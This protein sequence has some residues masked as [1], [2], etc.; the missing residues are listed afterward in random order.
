MNQESEHPHHGHEKSKAEHGGDHTHGHETH[1]GVKPSSIAAYYYYCPMCEGVES[2]KPGT[3][4]KCGMALEKNPTHPGAGKTI[5]TCPMHPEIE[6]DHPGNCPICGM[7]LE[8][9]TISAVPEENHEL[10]DMTWRLWIGTALALPVLI[11]SMGEMLFAHLGLSARLSQWIQF[12]LSTPVVWWIGWPFLERGFRSV[13]TWNLN[14]FTLIALG[15]ETAYL[16]S[17]VA[18]LA[19]DWF[20]PEMRTHGGVVGV[21]FE[22][23][24]VI[25]VLVA[26]GQVLE[27]RARSR[28]H[29]AIRGLLDLTPKMAHVVR[30]GHENDIP[31]DE[32]KVGDVLRVR[33][34]ER[35][36]VDG[37]I[38]DGVSAVDESTLTGESIPA[39]KTKGS[40]VSGGTLNGTGSF[41]IRAER[42]GAETLLAQIVQLVAQAQRSRAPIQ[43]IADKVSGIFVPAVVAIAA[44]TFIAWMIWGPEPTLAYA[45]TNAV[46]VL[47]IAC[48]CALGL[49]TPMSIMVG[50]GRGAHEGVLIKNAEALGKMEKVNTLV[51]DKTGTLSEGKPRVV[52]VRVESGVSETELISW[53]AAVE[54]LSEHPL[55]A[56][57]VQLAKARNLAVPP[58]ENFESFTGG[59]VSGTVNGRQVVIGQMELL[60]SN[61]IHAT[62]TEAEKMRGDG[63][64]VV[65]VGID[66]HLAGLLGIADPIKNGTPDALRELKQLGLRLI[67]LT[68]DHERTANAIASK[69]GINEVHAGVKPAEKHALIER[70]RAERNIVAMAGDG[71]NDAPALAAADVGIAMGTGTDV[72]MQSASVTLVKGDLTGIVRAVHLSRSVMRNIRQNLFLSFVY[73]ALGVPIAAGVL[74]PFTGWLLNPMIASVAMS[75]SSVSV[76]V[77]ALRLRHRSL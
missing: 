55:A 70:L 76:I 28:T 30:D 39:E 65:F 27:L 35:V 23:A 5:Y 75:L 56:A 44:L 67:M 40:K 68:G 32:V 61:H 48:P 66:G 59:G 17:A 34:G 49:A 8:P 45:I 13:T 77:N 47:I 51:L 72:A 18:L 60:R 10:L 26:L 71:I 33:P 43:K 73:N 2:D 19:P 16:F 41:L 36:P 9:K 24:A 21:Y 63:Q 7:A 15:V 20:P 12:A 3:C 42:V 69:L 31:L 53:S 50:V 62:D 25:T 4:P 74:Y 57:V 37:T 22:A 46:A 58:A 38:E 14:M 54:Q 64:T 52:S 29:S 1:G 6:Q 11:L